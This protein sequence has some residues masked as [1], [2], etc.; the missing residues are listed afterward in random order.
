MLRESRLAYTEVDPSVE[1]D[2]AVTGFNVSSVA[3]SS[4]DGQIG[5]SLNRLSISV[6]VEYINYMNEE[7]SFK[8][9]FSFFQDFESTENLFDIQESLTEEIFSQ[10]TEDVFN[11][12]F[13]NW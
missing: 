4:E 11:D 8:K 2:G 13:S 3:P 1:F 5:S 10:I 12:T 6:N 9:T 7:N